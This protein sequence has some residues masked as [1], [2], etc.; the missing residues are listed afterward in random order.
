MHVRIRRRRGGEGGLPEL[1]AVLGRFTPVAQALPPCA[2][3]ARV[4]GA[5]RL[6]G[7]GPADL[8]R[9]LR[10]QAAAW[11]GLDTAVGIGPSWTVA[12]TA[13]SRTGPDGVRHV[14]PEDVE[15]FLGPLPVGELYGIRRTQAEE[16]GRLGVET[17]GQLAALPPA[18][19][20]RILGR[21]A[22]PLQERARG[23]DRR[24]VVPGRATE[25]VGV[26]ADFAEDTLD[27]PRAR[28]TALRLAAELGARLRSRHQAAR[29]VTVVVRTADR[30]ELSRTRTLPAPSPHTDDLREAVYGILDGFGLQ[31][32]RMRRIGLVAD[33]VDDTQAHTQ[34]TLDRARE[35]R[36]RVEPVI[37]AL[38]ARY[39]PG[40]IGPAAAFAA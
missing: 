23:G 2:A 39:G 19:A 38:N 13:S 4:D 11:Y 9:R 1:M 36:L 33:A 25:T 40:T 32:A 31:R 35:A 8:A 10:L 37:D 21:Q 26:R 5:L 24:A 18:T 17:I 3:V 34:L 20:L 15:D 6:F 7:L 16:L 30:R 29:S 27:G 22:R 28:A 14:R 12:A